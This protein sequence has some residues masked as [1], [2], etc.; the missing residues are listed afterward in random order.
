MRSP[1]FGI[2]HGCV[3][4]TAIAFAAPASA[5]SQVVEEQLEVREVGVVADLP[6]SLRGLSADELAARLTI[7][8]GGIERQPASVGTLGG[9]GSDAY[10]RVVVVLDRERCSPE[11]QIGATA[12]LGSAAAKLVALGPTEIADLDGGLRPSGDA[13]RSAEELATRLAERSK[14]DCP[15]TSSAAG[16][17]RA[18]FA[19]ESLACP[20]GP[21]LLVWVGPGWGGDPAE[22]GAPRP[23]SRREL[24]PLALDLAAGGWVFLAAPITAADPTE[25]QPSIPDVE[26]RPGSDRHIF[27]VGVRGR[28]GRKP[29]TPEAYS[30]YVDVWLT[31]LRRLV[32]ATA[33][34][35]VLKPDELAPALDALAGRSVLWYRT[36][37]RPDGAPAMLVVRAEGEHGRA[38]R[39][40]Q[41]VPPSRP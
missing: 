11:I 32:G 16:L 41:W 12:A 33:G 14:E 5:Q 18:A 39:V 38:Y 17:D 40:P 27:G 28:S 2:E 36:D 6:A 7:L 20:A 26:S 34:E 3:L 1:R 10:G 4:L 22:D 30:R 13:T 15:V 9:P 35:L 23:A 21:C 31:P 19:A 25:S 8:E 37:R 24:E 29:L